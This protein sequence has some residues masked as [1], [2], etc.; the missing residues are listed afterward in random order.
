M[1]HDNYKQYFSYLIN[2][3]KIAFLYRKFWLY[4]IILY[5]LNGK[6]LDVGCGI[7]DLLS[8]KKNIIGVDI[9]PCAVSYCKNKGLDA[10]IMKVNKLPF[11]SKTFDCIVLDNVLEHI[12]DPLPLLD[13]I[14][15]VIKKHGILIIGVPGI[16]GYSY[17]PDHKKY[18]TKTTLISLMSSQGYIN[19]SIYGMPLNIDWLSDKIRQYCIY[20]RF[21][22]VK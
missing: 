4:P 12:R 15:R 14:S 20:A 9:N 17:D 18:Y 6:I 22:K 2:R 10:R 3:S 19:Q 1:K 5:K 16:K 11:N 13:E 8:Y 21:K 7:G